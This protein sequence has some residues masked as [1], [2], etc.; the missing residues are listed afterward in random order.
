MGITPKMAMGGAKDLEQTALYKGGEKMLAKG[1]ALTEQARTKPMTTAGQVVGSA[2]GPFGTGTGTF[3]G[4]VGDQVYR[5]PYNQQSSGFSKLKSAAKE[6][7]AMGVLDKTIGMTLSLGKGLLSTVFGTGARMVEQ[8]AAGEVLDLVSKPTVKD[9]IASK[10]AARVASYRSA[11]STV[12]REQAELLGIKLKATEKVGAPP[13]REQIATQK[14]EGA[15][16]ETADMIAKPKQTMTETA[17]GIKTTLE[18]AKDSFHKQ[19]SEDYKALDQAI[20]S[21]APKIKTERMDTVD[22]KFGKFQVP[23]DTTYGSVG[24]GNISANF[25]TASEA[26]SQVGMRGVAPKVYEPKPFEKAVTA[27]LEQIPSVTFEKAH[28]LRSDL[29]TKARM[30]E[31]G[32]NSKENLEVANRAIKSIDQEMERAARAAGEE[33][34][35]AWRNL[36]SAYKDGKAIFE[37]DAVTAMA[38]AKPE[39]LVASIAP[40]KMG[41]TDAK[42]IMDALAYNKATASESTREFQRAYAESI[43]KG[44]DPYQMKQRLDKIGGETLG[45]I[46]GRTPE[47]AKFLGAMNANAQLLERIGQSQ[48]KRDVMRDLVAG[49][50]GLLGAVTRAA[51]VGLDKQQEMMAAITVKAMENEGLKRE[52]FT[53]LRGLAMAPDSGVGPAGNALV[54]VLKKAFD[55]DGGKKKKRE[56]H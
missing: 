56:A 42:T 24:G 22:S 51:R 4:S 53:A 49:P 39:E 9:W 41:M 13:T 17:G 15:L 14:I 30:W 6:G 35:T 31:G 1:E 45:T 37:S 20:E 38:A 34:H 11:E 43:L 48:A 16:R 2:F 36:N 25:K 8:V 5:D 52:Y 3:L 26:S 28:Q 50:H 44:G 21:K 12:A 32:V 47:A 18:K 10:S 55:H 54:T 7:V 46:F 29:L 40:G 23:R 19:F 33:F 27:D